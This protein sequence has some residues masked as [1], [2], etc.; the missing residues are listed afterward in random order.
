MEVT[1][2][3][4]GPLRGDAHVGDALAQTRLEAVAQRGDARRLCGQLRHG[5][6][7]GDGERGRAGGILGAR[8]Q[9]ALLSAAVQEGLD[10]RLPRDDEGADPDGPAQLVRGDAERDEARAARA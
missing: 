6:F 5:E 10:P 1:G 8:A 3:A 2:Q 9:T 4:L 7:C